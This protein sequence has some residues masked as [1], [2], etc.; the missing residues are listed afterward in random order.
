MRPRSLTAGLAFALAIYTT[1][2]AADLAPRPAE[3]LYRG[4]TLIDV[5]SGTARANMAILTKGDRIIGVG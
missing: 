1:A 2:H 3:V 5:T 4:A